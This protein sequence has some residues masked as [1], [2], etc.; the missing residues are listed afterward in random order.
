MNDYSLYPAG[1]GTFGQYDETLASDPSVWNEFASAAYRVG[2]SQVEGSLL[3]VFEKVLKNDGNL[4]IQIFPSLYDSNDEQLT[5]QTF[6]LSGYFFNASQLPRPGFIDNAI[7]GLTKQNPLAVN[8][9]YT[10]QLTRFLFRYLLTLTA[11][12]CARE[13]KTSLRSLYASSWISPGAY[14]KW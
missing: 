4:T 10:P 9:E 1:M 6:T 12:C 11:T 8:P 7:R 3:W 5:D 14:R 2:H 13:I